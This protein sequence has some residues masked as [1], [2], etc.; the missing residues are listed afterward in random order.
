[1]RR[2]EPPLLRKPPEEYVR[3]QF[4]FASQPLGEPQNPKHLRQVI[5]VLGTD[6]LM[7]SADYP[8]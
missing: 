7:L 5:D 6:C 3:D 1:M 2:I 8:H 4:Y